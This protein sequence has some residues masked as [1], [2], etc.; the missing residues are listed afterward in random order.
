MSKTLHKKKTHLL[1]A[2]VCILGLVAALAAC[3]PP[4]ETKK[5]DA[6]A[7]S[8]Q[9]VK[10]PEPDSFGVITAEGW[11]DIY[12]DQYASYQ[13]NLS[14]APGAGKHDYLELYPALN[15]LYAG[16]AFSKGYEE[17]AGHLYTL[18]AIRTTPRITDKSL[19]NCITC[20]SPQFTALVNSNGAAEYAKPFAETIAL[21]TE[22]I[23]CYNCHENDPTKLT[24][25]NKFFLAALGNDVSKVPENAQVCGQCHNEYYFNADTKATTNPYVGLAAMAPDAILAYYD[26]MGFSDWK[27]PVTE[28]PMIKIQH[29]EFET[30]YGGGTQSNMAA[31]GYGCSDCHMA[32]ATAADGS[33]YTSHEWTSPLENQGL[34]DSTCKS[35]HP[36]LK[37]QVADW[38]ATE[39]ERVKAISLKIE[40][41]AKK[42]TDQ[43]NA[44]TLAG[45][46]LAQLQKLHR[47]SQ[48]Y[49]DFVMVENSEG[50]HNP[51]FTK[52]TL[53]K[54]EKAVDEALAML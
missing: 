10:M 42:M 34:L 12:P 54:A 52:A 50:A 47:N 53:D 46:K 16:M 25:G 20:K 11:K 28:T 48:F 5:E 36:D 7:G 35:C 8:K 3:S 37:K 51:K 4:A 13:A 26:E 44:G 49:W 45:D 29:P 32:P 17:A 24:V 2:T 43:V 9:E 31:L 6:S 14:N 33:E 21:M 19:A 40:E 1:L 38:Q 23:S 39:D 18:D 30:I 41:L 27:Y 15:T 22:P